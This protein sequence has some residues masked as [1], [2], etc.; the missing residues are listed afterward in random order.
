MNGVV[1]SM[2]K[3]KPNLKTNVIR[4]KPTINPI[5]ISGFLL[6]AQK[7]AFDQVL[8]SDWVICSDIIQTCNKV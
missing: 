8:Q 5:Q 4:V 6:N 1:S 2:C 3:I 7:K